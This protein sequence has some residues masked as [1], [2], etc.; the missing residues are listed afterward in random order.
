M[1][2]AGLS[3]S[4]ELYP[5]ETLRNGFITTDVINLTIVLPLII[6]GYLL[7]RRGLLVGL[8]LWTGSLFVISYH[9]IAYAAAHP[10]TWQFVIYCVIAG[11][12][13]WVIF[14]LIRA[15]KLP[16]INRQLAGAVPVYYTAGVL[17]VM[18]LMFLIRAGL[19]IIEVL[20]AG[21]M[22]PP[23]EFADLFFSLVWIIGGVLLWKKKAVAYII[24]AGLILQTSILF[25]GLLIYFIL[26]PLITE[27]P[28]SIND[29]IAV[30]FMG[31]VSYVPVWLILRR[32]TK[33]S[34]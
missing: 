7:T 11:S 16:D 27:N 9:Y 31:W 5:D 32:I 12:T 34:N 4:A 25:I 19:K 33:R 23:T 26:Q 20:R 3:A 8:I 24:G 10:M 17:I 1:S 21:E 22:L 13:L 18:G 15:L 28:F 2:V 29:F 6:V 14:I 30:F